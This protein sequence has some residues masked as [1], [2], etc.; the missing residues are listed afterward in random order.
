M[1]MITFSYIIQ[2]IFK[3]G[4]ESM[5]NNNFF[6]KISFTIIFIV[7]LSF[8]A[9]NNQTGSSGGQNNDPSKKIEISISHYWG[10]KDPRAPILKEVFDKFQVDNPNVTLKIEEL[11]GDNY[12]D[13]FNTWAATGIVPDIILTGLL[14]YSQKYV[15]ANLALDMTPVFDSDK[16]WASMFPPTMFSETNFNGKI[17]FVPQGYSPMILY[18]NK[19][20]LNEY[21]LKSPETYDDFIN[22]LKT[23]KDGGKYI[24][25]TIFGKNAD[26]TPWWLAELAG[27]MGAGADYNAVCEGTGSFDKPALLDAAT[28]LNEICDYAGIGINGIEYNVSASQFTNEKAAFMLNGVWA[29]GQMENDTENGS[30]FIKKLDFLPFPYIKPEYKGYSSSGVDSGWMISSKI[31]SSKQDYAIDLVKRL[32]SKEVASKWYTEAKMLCGYKGVTVDKNSLGTFSKIIDISE[33]ANSFNDITTP[34]CAF[35]KADT[36]PKFRELIQLLIDKKIDEK[37]MAKQLDEVN[38]K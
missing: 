2:D 3:Q 14:P 35:R 28:K 36:D 31:D 25:V 13:K 5:S 11:P 22:C 33:K 6:K 29:L 26:N 17:Y 12:Q 8:T 10:G 9:C 23:I 27:V 4:V 38:L 1:K 37:E 20:I 7:L 18:T 21:G 34:W 16:E 30:E 24:P 19:N 15:D 32:C